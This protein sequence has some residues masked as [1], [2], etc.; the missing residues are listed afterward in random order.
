MKKNIVFGVLISA[1]CAYLAF[2]GVNFNALLKSI[3][4]VNYLYILA[5]LLIVI[6]AH[7]LRC[8]RWGKIMNTLVRYDQKTLFILGSLGFMA[9]N[10]LP[11]RL[12]EFARPYL[13]K[14]RS[15]IKMSATMA[16]IIVERVFDLLTLMLIMFIVLIK[17][18]LPDKIYKGGIIMLVISVSL[19]IML[20]LLA[21]KRDSSINKIDALLRMFPTK[22]AEPLNRLAHSFIDGLQILPDIGKTLYVLFLSVL[23]WALVGLSAYV[24]FLGFGFALPLINGYAITVIIA[25]GVM[26]P[27]APGF[28]GTYHYFCI[29]GMTKFG[30]SQADAGAYAILL[31]FFQMI[32]IIVLGLIM[33]PF[34]KISLSGII[35]HDDNENTFEDAKTG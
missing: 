20:I 8:Y 14:K 22:I 4:S 21:I 29:L 28:I 32:P 16:T 26:L 2:S 33:L 9:V 10:V 35:K 25:L 27:A 15:G 6:S 19:F 24:L 18:E 23:L 3:T 31:H 7:Y 12:G 11:A 34:Q 1:V 30:V 13:V 5:V 17:V